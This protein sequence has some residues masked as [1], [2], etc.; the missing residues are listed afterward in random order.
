MSKE[1]KLP[2]EKVINFHH[3]V[4]QLLF[5]STRAQ[6]DVQVAVA[7]LT[8]SGKSPDN[9]D[10]GKL[11]RVLKYL[12]GTTE[13]CLNLSV[14]TIAVTKWYIDAAH[15][16]HD[17]CKSHSGVVITLGK[18]MIASM[19]QMHKI[20][21]KSFIEIKLIAVE[22]LWHRYCEQGTSYKN[23]GTSWDQAPYTKTIK[24]SY[25]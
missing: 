1:T 12:N 24:V 16:V 10:W 6:R 8:T 2:E 13:T 25:C 14:E 4:A 22:A 7:F 5:L 17:D 23:R 11:N 15:V 19:L 18:G 9:D 3:N 20:N 21:R